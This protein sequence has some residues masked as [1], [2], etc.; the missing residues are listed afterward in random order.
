MPT[1]THLRLFRTSTRLVHPATIL[2]GASISRQLCSS[3][4]AQLIMVSLALS[5]TPP[6]NLS[7]QHIYMRD[8]H[9]HCCL[10][11]H[12][13]FIRDYSPFAPKVKRWTDI[14][15]TNRP[16]YTNRTKRTW[17]TKPL[18]P[19]HRHS[20]TQEQKHWQSSLSRTSNR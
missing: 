17:T 13:Y 18:T 14:R 15:N 16:R 1:L 2:L 8:R 11:L 19:T 20:P 6:N 12:N 9:N 7:Y 3:Q 10:S 5:P 4:M